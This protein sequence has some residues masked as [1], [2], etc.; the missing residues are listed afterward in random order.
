MPAKEPDVGAYR[1]LG[2]R[3]TGSVIIF[4]LL[5]LGLGQ[6]GNATLMKLLEGLNVLLGVGD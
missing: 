2:G 4:G 5:D 1:V 6:G 3:D